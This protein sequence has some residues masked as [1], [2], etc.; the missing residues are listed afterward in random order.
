MHQEIVTLKNGLT[1]ELRYEGPPEKYLLVICHG[2]KSSPN[3][4]GIV[5][6]AHGLNRKGHATFTFRF[7]G[8][9]PLDLERQVGDI[10]NI[11]EHFANYDSIVLIGGQLRGA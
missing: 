4:P 10:Q 6:T 11:A 7:S 9:N 8:K 2:Y 1:G 3:H 5:A